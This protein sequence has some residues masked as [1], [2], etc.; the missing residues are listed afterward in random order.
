LTPRRCAAATRKNDG[1]E[2]YVEITGRSP[3]SWTTRTPSPG[4]RARRSTAT[5]DVVVVGGG[6]GGLLAGARLREAG[7]D[8]LCIIEK[9]GDFGGTWYWNRY[10]GAQCDTELHLPAAARRDRLHADREVR[11]RPRSSSTRAHR[12][13]LRPVP[14]AL[15]QTRSPRCAGTTTPR[16]GVV[17]TDRGDASAPAS[18]CWP[19][20]R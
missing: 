3:T 13:A 12:P 1:N 19:P 14:A 6:F 18:S 9:G 20:A 15:F 10:P 2:Q 16:A 5:V 17:R 11:R 8:D 7:V 4:S